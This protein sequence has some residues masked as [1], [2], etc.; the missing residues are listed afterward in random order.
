MQDVIL[1]TVYQPIKRY[2]TFFQCASSDRYQTENERKREKARTSESGTMS[3]T[4]VETKA[5][6]VR[7]GMKPMLCCVPQVVV[8]WGS[9]GRRFDSCMC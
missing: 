1:P 7:A 2:A 9:W 4:T 8:D 6:V 3:V 5:T